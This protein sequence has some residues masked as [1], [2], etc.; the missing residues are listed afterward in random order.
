MKLL[1]DHC[2]DRRLRR[3]LPAHEVKTAYEMGWAEYKN[4][5]LLMAAAAEFDALITIDRNIKHQQNLATL[6]LTVVILAG[7]SNRLE[8]LSLLIP[9]LEE[10][11]S[12]FKACHLLE[13][14][15]V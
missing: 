7:Q 12:N 1:L 3:F 2:V 5:Q 4:G 13:I 9:A 11:L 8:H 15:E 14:G 6:P 10:F